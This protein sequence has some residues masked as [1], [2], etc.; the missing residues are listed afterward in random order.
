MVVAVHHDRRPGL[1]QGGAELL[2]RAG[3]RVGGGAVGHDARVALDQAL[4]SRG[5]VVR[6]VAATLA[7]EPDRRRIR[8]DR[9]Q[10]GQRLGERAGIGRCGE[11]AQH[12]AV[13]PGEQAREAPLHASARRVHHRTAEADLVVVRHG[14]LDGRRPGAVARALRHRHGGPAARGEHVEPV[15]L[16]VDLVLPPARDVEAQQVAGPGVHVDPVGVVVR[17]PQLGER[18]GTEVPGRQEVGHGALPDGRRQWPMPRPPSTGI[19]APETYA[20]SAEETHAT[21]PATSAAVP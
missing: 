16:Q 10:G 2:D 9:V 4:Q 1:R 19:T 7:R 15:E 14:D 8:A 18:G 21:T 3:E 20:A 6:V 13:V 17:G 5:R 11:A 12:L